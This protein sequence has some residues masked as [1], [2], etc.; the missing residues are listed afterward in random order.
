VRATPRLRSGGGVWG[1]RGGTTRAVSASRFLRVSCACRSES[2]SRLCARC[3][4]TI[5]TLTTRA[6]T[7]CPPGR[8]D[9]ADAAPA[10]SA[11]TARRCAWPR[12]R[13]R[14]TRWGWSPSGDGRPDRRVRA[15][16]GGGRALHAPVSAARGLTRFVGG[17]GERGEEERGGRGRTAMNCRVALS[18]QLSLSITGLVLFGAAGSGSGLSLGAEPTLSIGGAVGGWCLAGGSIL[19]GTAPGTFRCRA[20]QVWAGTSAI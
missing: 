17:T 1:G 19:Y 20:A 4:P 3:T 14:L 16:R 7:D 9:G 2:A 5:C 10:R 12:G 13:S 8:Q 11:S 15:D 18:F 6:R